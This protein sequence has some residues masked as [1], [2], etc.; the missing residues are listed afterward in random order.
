MFSADS[1]I[2]SQFLELDLKRIAKKWDE[3]QYFAKFV[4]AC[5]P[6]LRPK[7]LDIKTRDI[8]RKSEEM[9]GL[10][11]THF[12]SAHPSHRAYRDFQ[13]AHIRADESVQTFKDRIVN[14]LKRAR[15]SLP[16]D[17]LKFL[18]GTKMID[19][20]PEDVQPHLRSRYIKD[21]DELANSCQEYWDVHIGKVCS[22]SE[23]QAKK[24][25]T[26]IEDEDDIESS[27][28]IKN[29]DS[30][31]LE[32]LT[33][34]LDKISIIVDS[35]ARKFVTPRFTNSQSYRTV[36]CSS[37]GLRGHSKENCRGQV[38]CRRCHKQ[39]HVE[40]LCRANLNSDLSYTV[41]N[42]HRDRNY[43]VIDMYLRDSQRLCKAL[44]DT[45]SCVSLIRSNLIIASTIEKSANNL[46][47]ANGDHLN[48]LGK[49]RLNIE[50]NKETFSWEFVVV[51]KLDFDAILGR[52][53]IAENKFIVDVELPWPLI[54]KSNYT[55]VSTVDQNSTAGI[56]D[57]IKAQYSDIFSTR[58]GYTD[59][60]KHRIETGNH[61][62]IK[63]R[64]YRIP[65]SLT[66]EVKSQIE[67]ML[68]D[69]IIRP[70]SSPWCAPMVLV[71]KKNGSYRMCIDYRRLNS[72]TQKDEYPLPLMEE[73]L[74]RLAGAKIF[75]IFD[76]VNGYWQ[77]AIEESD[78]E[79]TAFSPGPGLGLYEFNAMPFGLC[80][81]PSTF[82]RLMDKAL[83]GLNNCFSYMDDI[84]VFSEDV[85]THRND[86]IAL[87]E[88][89]RILNLR[90]NIGKCQ[91]FV[92]KIKY[93]G[94]LVDEHGIIPDP[95]DI[96]PIISWKTPKDADE[97]RRFLGTCGVYHRFIRNYSNI[98]EP[99]FQEYICTTKY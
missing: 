36:V 22:L 55:A 85:Q 2:E 50:L 51:P 30:S 39:G 20:M 8:P 18:V 34:R 87:L 88:R 79:K 95:E 71:K 60:T 90:V 74:D 19:S 80:N 9:K 12:K 7:L 5:P 44:I 68:S 32:S 42:I 16:D 78:K 48:S 83:Y 38:F 14:L 10:I 33:N 67:Q 57:N 45:G 61:S 82:Q 70:S 63:C 56:I 76:L 91:L 65:I 58:S 29:S 4:L 75:S 93:L 64:P 37:C 59:I 69:K 17:D 6:E 89:L 40:R 66:K 28:A 81:A 94:F 99:L 52:D 46:S 13:K 92:K 77:C 72:I 98:A 54:H 41:S 84:I 96:E 43:C 21:L 11:R 23:E 49:T 26:K 73:L 1:D 86:V 53:F 15:P 27:C 25:Q 24:V 97:L 31:A 35:L 62:P 3:D 47:L